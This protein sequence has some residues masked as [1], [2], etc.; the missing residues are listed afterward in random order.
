MIKYLFLIIS[1]PLQSLPDFVGS[2][3]D[4]VALVGITNTVPYKIF[5]YDDLHYVVQTG[6]TSNLHGCWFE[7]SNIVVMQSRGTA[8]VIKMIVD[9]KLVTCLLAVF[10]GGPSVYRYISEIFCPTK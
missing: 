1:F 8:N 10:T 4:P 3:C 5:L 7:Q 9:H 6:L 2:R